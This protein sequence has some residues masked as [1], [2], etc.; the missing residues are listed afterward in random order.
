MEEER[1]D[2]HGADARQL[3]AQLHYAKI[4]RQL[5]EVQVTRKLVFTT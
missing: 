1:A 2:G 4:L 3:S 5:A